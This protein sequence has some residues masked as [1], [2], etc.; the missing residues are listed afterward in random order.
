MANSENRDAVAV[1]VDVP[2]RPVRAVR[3]NVILPEDLLAAIDRFTPNRSRFLAEAA[4]D[5]LRGRVG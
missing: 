1:L 2:V 4:R 5:R 3:V